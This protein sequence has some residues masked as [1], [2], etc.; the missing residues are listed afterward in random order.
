M[1][2]GGQDRSEADPGAVALPMRSPGH[3]GMTN[4]SQSTAVPS[5]VSVLR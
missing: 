5:L 3:D 2:P 1:Y 4:P